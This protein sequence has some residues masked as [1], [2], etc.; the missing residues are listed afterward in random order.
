[1]N[2]FLTAIRENARSLA[3]KVTHFDVTGEV[4]QCPKYEPALQPYL[5]TFSF[6]DRRTENP[7]TFSFVG[8]NGVSHSEYHPQE[9]AREH[10]ICLSKYLAAHYSDLP[11]ELD[12]LQVRLRVPVPTHAQPLLAQ[13]RTEVGEVV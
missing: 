10:V 9:L 8:R 12:P 13:T 2:G 6:L 4:R 11:F 1:M 7:R 3:G 5:F